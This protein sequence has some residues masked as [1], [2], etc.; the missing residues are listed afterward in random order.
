MEDEGARHPGHLGKYRVDEIIG[1]GAMGVVYRGYDPAI[2]RMVALKTIHRELLAGE[3]GAQ[4][5]S[6]FQ[7]EVRAAGRCLHPNIVAVFDY[8]EEN[9]MPFLAMEYVRGRKLSE[10]LSNGVRFS[11]ATALFIIRQVLAG[12]GMPTA[13][14]SSI[15]TSNRL[16][17]SSLTT[18]VR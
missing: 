13:W 3:Q 4:W 16:T 7:Q 6:R 15:A 8:G 1:R 2:D 11:P 17:S 18:T 12:L 14:G 10:H 5:Q 9:G